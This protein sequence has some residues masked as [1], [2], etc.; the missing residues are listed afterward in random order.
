[1]VLCVLYT[2]ESPYEKKT[3]NIRKEMK[4]MRKNKNWKIPNTVDQT[5]SGIFQRKREVR[6]W[7][8]MKTHKLHL[9]YNQPL[10]KNK[11]KNIK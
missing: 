4:E 8:R 7:K 11:C 3:K 6:K 9:Y 1:M 2:Y 10:L 5:E